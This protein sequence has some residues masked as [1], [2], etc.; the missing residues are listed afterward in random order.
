ML[1]IADFDWSLTFKYQNLHVE[2]ILDDFFEKTYTFFKL[3]WIK[4]QKFVPT[5][6][7]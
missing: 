7:K 4:Y 3:P 1:E 6:L 5:A 2:N